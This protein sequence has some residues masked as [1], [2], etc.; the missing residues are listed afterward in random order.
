MNGD[1]NQWACFHSQCSL[2]IIEDSH[3]GLHSRMGR[4]TQK[5]PQELAL[6]MG[7]ISLGHLL[8]KRNRIKIKGQEGDHNL[9]NPFLNTR[10]SHSNNDISLSRRI[11][12]LLWAIMMHTASCNLEYA[13]WFCFDHSST[14]A[15]GRYEEYTNSI[16]VIFVQR[17][18]NKTGDLKY[19]KWMK[20]LIYLWEPIYR[21]GISK[22]KHLLHQSRA[23]ALTFA[24][25]PQCWGQIFV[26]D[27]RDHQRLTRLAS[28]SHSPMFDPSS[29]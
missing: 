2:Q 1:T 24:W 26:L 20:G 25:Y 11:V 22:T 16:V 29:H 12:C 8:K 27:C 4:K 5:H 3:K 18:K 17:P 28:F 13:Y 7:Q 15:E 6:E 19:I 23:E 21:K 9:Q 10:T 14:D